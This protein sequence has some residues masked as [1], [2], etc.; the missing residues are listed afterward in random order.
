MHRQLSRPHLPCG[1]QR[2]IIVNMSGFSV[3]LTPLQR[4]MAGERSTLVSMPGCALS[5]GN[6]F[7][8]N[9]LTKIN[10]EENLLPIVL[11]ILRVRKI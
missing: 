9:S 6:R 7:N 2:C 5:T 4:T 8:P 3:P 11:Q 1:C 10:Q